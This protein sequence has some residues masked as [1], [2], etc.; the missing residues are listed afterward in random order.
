[1]ILFFRNSIYLLIQPLNIHDHLLFCIKKT[2]ISSWKSRWQTLSKALTSLFRPLIARALPDIGPIWQIQQNQ[3]ISG[4]GAISFDM[5]PRPDSGQ[6][7]AALICPGRRQ[8]RNLAA[9]N[10]NK[11]RCPRSADRRGPRGPWLAV[12]GAL[13]R[14][15]FLLLLLFRGVGHWCRLTGCGANGR[16]NKKLNTFD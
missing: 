7:E 9:Q 8:D 2:P 12:V 15:F 1:M 5:P 4:E 11:Q 3:L 6:T 14:T 16:G 13:G 10:N